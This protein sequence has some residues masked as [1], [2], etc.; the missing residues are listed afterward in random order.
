[1]TGTRLLVLGMHTLSL[2]LALLAVTSIAP[3]GLDFAFFYVIAGGYWL[4]SAYRIV[5]GKDALARKVE[6]FLDSRARD[7]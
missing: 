6:S 7:R 5:T 2:V 4:Y 1:M 3:A